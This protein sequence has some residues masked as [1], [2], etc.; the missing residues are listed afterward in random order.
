MS[1]ASGETKGQK[2]NE[3]GGGDVEDHEDRKTQTRR[4]QKVGESGGGG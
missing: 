2:P 4:P 3:S 1:A